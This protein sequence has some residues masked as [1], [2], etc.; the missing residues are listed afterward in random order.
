MVRT[1]GPIP[2]IRSD[3]CQTL[4]VTDAVMADDSNPL[5]IVNDRLQRSLGVDVRRRPASAPVTQLLTLR[6]AQVA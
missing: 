5:L 3:D 4:Q 2:P 6:Q 1:L